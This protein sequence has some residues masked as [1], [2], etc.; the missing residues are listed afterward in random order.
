VV[1]RSTDHIKT[2]VIEFVMDGLDFISQGVFDLLIVSVGLET[3]DRDLMKNGRPRDGRR[4]QLDGQ[5]RWRTGPGSGAM[6][7][8]AGGA[9]R[10]GSGGLNLPGFAPTGKA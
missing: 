10:R 5:Q 9:A 3:D 2:G 4:R 8:L 6:G 1:H 7:D